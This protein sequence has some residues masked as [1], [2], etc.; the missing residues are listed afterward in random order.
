MIRKK[1]SNMNGRIQNN[2]NMLCFVAQSC[3]TLCH[4]MNC[5]PPDSSFHE[6]SPGKNTRMGCHVLLQGIFPTQGS[7]PGLLHHRWILYCLSHQGNPRILEWVAYPFSRRNSQPRN[8]TRV[9]CV[10][11]RFFTNWA[12]QEAQWLLQSGLNS[13]LLD[14]GRGCVLDK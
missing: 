6:D 3:P 5:S 2:V 13:D 12:T 4:P 1:K 9:S 8:R 7:N 14:W 11:D 10:A